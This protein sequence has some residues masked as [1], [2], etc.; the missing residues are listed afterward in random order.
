MDL[1]LLTED[2]LEDFNE[3]AAIK[4]YCG[5]MLREVAERQAFEEII[6]R[7]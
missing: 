1:S 7:R 5:N 4:Q 2:E 3:R 6:L